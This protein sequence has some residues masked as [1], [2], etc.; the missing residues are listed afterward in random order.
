MARTNGRVSRSAAALA[1][2]LGILAGGASPASAAVVIDTVSP[3]VARAGA[4]T[5]FTI[6]GS[7]FS[8]A[9]VVTVEPDGV[10]QSVVATPTS[11]TAT[12][13][14]PAGA[15]TGTRDVRV[16][17]GADSRLERDII[18]LRPTTG[19]YHA[20]TPVRLLDTRDPGGTK[21][22]PASTTDLTVTGRAGVPATG[23]AAVV[24]NVTATEATAATFVTAYPAGNPRPV[25]SNLNVVQGQTVPN[26]VTVA[27]GGT[28]Q[29]SFYNHQGAVHLV[30]DIA[31]WYGA[32]GAEAGAAFVPSGPRRLLDTRE[33]PAVVGPGGVVAVEVGGGSP[34]AAAALNVTVTEP[35]AD[36]FVTVYPSGAARPL[37]SNLNMRAGQTVANMV[38]TAVGAD[39]K[40]LLY[41]HTGSTHIVVDLLGIYDDSDLPVFGGQF[42]GAVPVRALDTRDASSPTVGQPVGQGQALVLPIAGQ[43]G[44]PPSANAVVVNVTAT[45]PTSASFLTVWATDEERPRASNLNMERGQT[46]PNLAVIPLAID[47]SISIYNHGGSAHVVVDVVGWYR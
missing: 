36:S 45:E 10:T 23:V 8:G 7:G 37:A 38:I 28:G 24:L 13:S 33:V 12:V 14:F 32:E 29:V 2:T 3:S 47:G 6:T 21:P 43:V 16:V 39:G 30:V 35:T 20:M 40:V 26:L 17:T 31:G 18:V 22:G 41:N 19:E 11:I 5:V 34:L 44:V 25:A 15:R 1:L 9:S 42:T 46:V 27:V 4:T